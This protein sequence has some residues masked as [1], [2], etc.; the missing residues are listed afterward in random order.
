[1]KFNAVTGEPVKM[2]FEE[3][4]DKYV[5]PENDP[6]FL[7]GS[8]D[9]FLWLS[10]RDGFD[11]YYLYD[12][13]GN[14]IKQVTS[15]E[16]VVTG[17]EGFDESG[18]NIFFTGTK[19]GAINQNL[20]KVNIESDEMTRLTKEDGYHSV[21]VNDSGDFIIDS[22]TSNDVPRTAQILDGD[23]EVVN[24]VQKSDDPL[25]DYKL[26]KI[27]YLKIK[28]ADGVTDLNARIIYPVD[29]DPNKK[30]PVIVFVYGGPHAQMVLNTYPF[31]RYHLWNQ[32]MAQ[33]GYIVFTVDNRG[34]ANRGRDFEQAI[35][36]NLG[37]VEV[38]DQLAGLDYLKA[39]G[40]ADLDRVGVFGWSYG[41]FMTGSLM[42]RTDGAY[43]VGV[44]GGTVCDWKYYEVMYGERYM[45][46]PESNPEGY[47]AS[48]L[49]NRIT[50]LK[51]K[52]LLL[53]GTSDPVVV[54]QH[55][56]M[57]AKKAAENNIPLDYFPYI[58]HGHGVGGPDALQMQHKITNYF[59][60]NL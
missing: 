37:E 58:H 38:A 17:F 59:L 50:D 4:S 41:G 10:E 57:L 29:F 42:M 24:T 19:D 49:L 26:G 34:S 9:K 46:T 25:K 51:G 43:K 44:A 6:I 45:D 8:S 35:F 22:Y 60:E 32:L 23:G 52:L 14:L 27:E 28:A 20:Y 15:G 48:S 33:K 1:M 18:E 30:Y 53:H 2:L 31:G 11:H 47:E 56:L 3:E 13:D 36:R 39:Q 40:F 16:W 12:T 55:S 7:P 21:Q 54:W 5:E